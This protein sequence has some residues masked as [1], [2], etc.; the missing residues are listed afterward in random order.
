MRTAWV[1]MILTLVLGVAGCAS[2]QPPTPAPKSHLASRIG[3]FCL[4]QLRRGDSLGAMRDLPIGP[5]ITGVNDSKV[6]LKGTLEEASE[7][8]ISLTNDKGTYCIPHSAILL[9]QFEP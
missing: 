5:D 4:V 6:S 9:I 8:W 1:A 2:N 7:D 3:K